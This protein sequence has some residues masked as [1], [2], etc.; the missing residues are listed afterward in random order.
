MANIFNVPSNGELDGMDLAGLREVGKNLNA[1]RDAM[2]KEYRNSSNYL[3]ARIEEQT[4]VEQK[5]RRE[6]DPESY[7]ELHQGIGTDKPK[8]K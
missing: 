1:Q 5:A 3:H 4:K 8:V 2:T 6:K 7:D